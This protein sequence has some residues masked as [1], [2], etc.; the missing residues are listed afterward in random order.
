MNLRVLTDRIHDGEQ[1]TVHD[2]A[3]TA[4]AQER[5]RDADHGQEPGGGTGVQEKLD[6][7]HD[8]DPETNAL[9]E[10]FLRE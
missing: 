6:A 8:G 5:E 9:R 10:V 2:H 1:K 4:V 7:E 3:R